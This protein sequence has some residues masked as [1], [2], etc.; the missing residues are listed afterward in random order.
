METAPAEPTAPTPPAVVIETSKGSIE[1]ALWEDKAPTTVSNFLAYVDD[2]HYTDLIFHRVIDGF[3]IQGGG[4]DAAMRQKQTH[5]PIKN[6][7]S[8]EAPNARGT[9]AMARTADINSATSQFFINLVD[10]AF[11]NHRDTTARGYGYCA[12]GEVTEGMDVVD[13]IGKVATGNHGMHGDVPTE[14]V[15]IKEIR[16]K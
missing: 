1:L 8:K 12:F 13:A 5:A 9:I 10:N 11:L 7:A 15:V 14:A 6:E 4:F 2:D 16:R 3:M